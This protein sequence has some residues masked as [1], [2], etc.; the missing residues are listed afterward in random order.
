[1]IILINDRI[2]DKIVIFYYFL[3]SLISLKPNSS[4]HSAATPSPYFYG[5]NKKTNTTHKNEI[6][7]AISKTFYFKRE[8]N[9]P[10]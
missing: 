8:D 9:Q 6:K 7:K 2:L 1:M 4:K 5:T 3:N 10:N